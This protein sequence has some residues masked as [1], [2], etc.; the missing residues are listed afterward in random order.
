[1]WILYPH[2]QETPKHENKELTPILRIITSAESRNEPDFVEK[3]TELTDA[4]D[5]S[6]QANLENFSADHTGMSEGETDMTKRERE[7]VQI[8]TDAAG[9]PVYT[10][11]EGKNRQD[12]LIKAAQTLLAYGMLDGCKPEQ[13][14]KV[15]Q[16]PTFRQ[17]AEQWWELYKLP[18]L[19]HTTR[20][21][22]RNL[23]D[24]HILPYFGKMR[25][26]EI[27]TNTIQAFYNA[28]REKAKSPTRQMSIL[29]HQVFDMAVEDGYM[30]TNPTES[31]RLSMSGGKKKREALSM[32]EA[33]DILHS[34]DQLLPQ[35][36]MTTALLLLTGMRRGET[37]GLCWEHID[38][39]KKLIHVEQAVTFCNNQPV[40]G[41]TKSEAGN[42]SIPLN[43]QLEA[44]LL[45]E[46]KENGFVLGDGD[47]PLTERTFTRL[48][49]RI[50]KKI[51]LH[52]ATPHILR[53][54][55]IT[56]AASS[57]IDV[58]TLQSIAGHSDIKMTMERYAHAREEKVIQAGTM[59]G[60]VFKAG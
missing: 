37:L 39:D 35:E 8:G 45:P 55:Y 26:D 41:E 18:K 50:E 21:T 15:P 30:R 38:W 17:Y 11:V 58:K 2:E 3:N 6:R 23:L 16:T 51:D 27:S 40:L 46:R 28:N 13:Q 34:L 29:L 7:R 24:N 20:T 25:L 32:R 54:T 19:R 12:F 49:Q 53:H 44:I 42:R 52:D 4:G 36:R 56:M 22:Y 31:K 33:Q 14:E 10:W 48:W 43:A 57:G 9:K 59:I 1:M 47:K 5:A 60:H